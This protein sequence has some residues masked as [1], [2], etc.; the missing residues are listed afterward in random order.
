MIDSKAQVKTWLELP[1]N[2]YVN[3]LRRS[4][5][6]VRH[7]KKEY[8]I[9]ETVKFGKSASWRIVQSIR[10]VAAK[11]SSIPREEVQV[12]KPEGYKYEGD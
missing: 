9:N 6:I 8:L 4:P 1:V 2:A 10:N 5:V 7:G 12:D 3:Q 11:L